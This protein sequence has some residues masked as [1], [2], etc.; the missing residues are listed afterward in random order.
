MCYTPDHFVD[1]VML[2]LDMGLYFNFTVDQAMGRQF[3]YKEDGTLS[4]PGLYQLSGKLRFKE[5][6]FRL[7]LFP[8]T[9]WVSD[10]ALVFDKMLFNGY[11]ASALD[12]AEYCYCSGNPTL[13]DKKSRR[14]SKFVCYPN[15]TC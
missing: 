13:K 6:G 8:Q 14:E 1:E 12:K 10:C 3:G 4:Y 5:K 2:N 11:D 7:T 15:A 9:T